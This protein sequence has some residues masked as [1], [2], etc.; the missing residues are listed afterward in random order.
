MKAADRT[1]WT[2]YGDALETAATWLLIAASLGALW[3]LRPVSA[4]PID[5][6]PLPPTV[7][8]SLDGAH[9]LGS[10]AASVGV[11][12]YG[13]F[14]C[15]YCAQFTSN[16][17]SRLERDYVATGKVVLAFRH[18]PLEEIHLLALRAA[19]A[20][21]CAGQQSS[22]W[23]MQVALFRDFDQL[24][25]ERFHAIARSLALAPGPFEQCMDGPSSDRLRTTIRQ[26]RHD[27]EMLGIGST[28]T[29]LIGK[30]DSSHRLRVETVLMGA[31][32]YSDFATAIDQLLR[33]NS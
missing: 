2:R 18:L 12:E 15:R 13:D 5:R 8:V 29:F 33:K 22:F 1:W 24:S 4:G 27:A 21:E 14:Q 20:A 28:P 25:E 16:T 11:L 3:L 10:D 7:P 26:S 9:R 30:I 32:T 17:F 6:T 19:E 23:P 31:P